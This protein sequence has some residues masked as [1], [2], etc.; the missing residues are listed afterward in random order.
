MTAEDAADYY[1]HRNPVDRGT[2]SGVIMARLDVEDATRA[3]Y[4]Q[5][6]ARRT[7]PATFVLCCIPF[8]TDG[9]ALGDTV[10]T[11]ADD[12]KSYVVTKVLARS[13]HTTYRVRVDTSDRT[14]RPQLVA[15]VDGIGCRWEWSSDGFVAVSAATLHQRDQLEAALSERTA[16]A[17]IDWGVR[18][19]A[20]PRDS[21]ATGDRRTFR[22]RAGCTLM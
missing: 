13:G 2:A 16:A 8:F 20:R 22:D 17:V 1:T 21:V 19:N 14:R 4:E 15:A 9:L 7:G 6:W 10:Q 12:L 11:E 5:L 18:L 3:Q